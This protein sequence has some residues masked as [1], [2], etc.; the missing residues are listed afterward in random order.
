MK[1]WIKTPGGWRSSPSIDTINRASEE[2]D[3][4][5]V[6]WTTYR[7]PRAGGKLYVVRTSRRVA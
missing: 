2:A 1:Y 5:G 7:Q 6:E 4:L 3:R